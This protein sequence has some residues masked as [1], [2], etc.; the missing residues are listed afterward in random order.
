MSWVRKIV[1]GR[2]WLL[3][4]CCRVKVLIQ[5][6]VSFLLVYSNLIAC[7]LGDLRLGQFVANT[8]AGFCTRNDPALEKGEKKLKCSQICQ[9]FCQQHV[10]NTQCLLC[11]ADFTTQ[12]FSSSF[13]S[14]LLWIIVKP[15]FQEAA[16]LNLL[17]IL[18]TFF[19]TGT[20]LKKKEICN[21]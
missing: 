19:F 17:L 15:E 5:Q 1:K 12:M 10:G 3:Q 20:G 13:Q 9:F 4:M 6:T 14:T 2:N 8:L 21:H 7:A 11:R 18:K 16:A